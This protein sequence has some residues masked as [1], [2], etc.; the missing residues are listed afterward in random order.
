MSVANLTRYVP[1]IKICDDYPYIKMSR[2]KS[3]SKSYVKFE[4]A[5]E[6]SSS[7]LQQLRAEIGSIEQ[8]AR[9]QLSLNKNPSDI[10][11]AVVAKLSQL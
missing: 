4:D 6:A 10:V 2:S 8:Y 5:M 7:S 9:D 1:E 3:K 11:L